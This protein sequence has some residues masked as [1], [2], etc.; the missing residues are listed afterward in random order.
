MVDEGQEGQSQ[1]YM[2]ATTILSLYMTLDTLGRPCQCQVLIMAQMSQSFGFPSLDE[3][4][5]VISFMASSRSTL[6]RKYVAQFQHLGFTEPVTNLQKNAGICDFSQDEVF[7]LGGFL[8]SQRLIIS[9]CSIPKMNL[10]VK[11]PLS[12][13][14]G[15][16]AKLV[17]GLPMGV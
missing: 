6:W 8:I 17:N 13:V 15:C 11:L 4:A 12:M 2:G 10:G 7:N 9:Q 3:Q 1:P 16:S 14:L 5:Y